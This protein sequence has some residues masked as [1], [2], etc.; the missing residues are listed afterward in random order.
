MEGQGEEVAFFVADGN[1]YTSL[2]ASL[3]IPS[4]PNTIRICS[5]G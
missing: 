5:R 4:S 1:K 2:F 3:W